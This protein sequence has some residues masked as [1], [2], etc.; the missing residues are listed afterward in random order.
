MTFRNNHKTAVKR[1]VNTK[2][3]PVSS[4]TIIYLTRKESLS[5]YK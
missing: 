2:W 1:T 3:P 5:C 4:A